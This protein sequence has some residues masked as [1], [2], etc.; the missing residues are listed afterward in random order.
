[1]WWLLAFVSAAL[2]GCYDSAKKISLK[3]NAV[4]PVLFLNTVLSALIFS[5]FLF[6]SGFGGWAVQKYILAKSAA[7]LR[8]LSN[9]QPFVSRKD[10]AFRG[11]HFFFK[12]DDNIFFL[13]RNLLIMDSG[14]Q[15]HLLPH[16]F[17]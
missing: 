3:N 10:R 6:S 7:E 5:P 4:I 14:H 2:L 11:L 8:I 1:M 16:K 17:S 12:S 15:I 13:L 9:R